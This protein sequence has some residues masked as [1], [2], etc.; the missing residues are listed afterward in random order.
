MKN[1]KRFKFDYFLVGMI[2]FFVWEV[3]FIYLLATTRPSNAPR[4][5]MNTGFN[6]NSVYIIIPLVLSLVFTL[7]GAIKKTRAEKSAYK[8]YF[9]TI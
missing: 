6:L 1:S 2:I 5:F 3:T 8:R 4:Y 9:D 7:I